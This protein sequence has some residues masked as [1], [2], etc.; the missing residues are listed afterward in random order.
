MKLSEKFLVF[1]NE[2]K[3]EHEK[4]LKENGA[5]YEYPKKMDPNIN[6]AYKR[7]GRIYR[8]FDDYQRSIWCFKYFI[9]NNAP[10]SKHDGLT[11][12]DIANASTVHESSIYLIEV[13]VYLNLSDTDPETANKLFGWAAENFV[14]PQKEFDFW[15]KQQYYD[16]IAVA[17]LW[18]GYSL[19][20][21]GEYK[22]AHELLVQVAPYLDRYKKT[23]VE[24]WRTVE[25]ALTKAVVP[26]CEYKLEPSAENLERA[27]N[28]I[29]EFIKR[30][31]ENRDKLEAYLYYFHLKEKFADIYNAD[32]PVCTSARPVKKKAKAKKL[33]K[34]PEED[35]EKPGII[36][37]TT[38][39]GGYE[40][41]L[42]TNQ[43]LEKY[44]A[45]IEEMEDFPLLASVME[46]YVMDSSIDPEFLE[47]ECRRLL[48]RKDIEK[49]MRDMTLVLLEAAMDAIGTG[50][51]LSFYLQIY[52][53]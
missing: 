22:E 14:I 16:N 40:E 11:D 6:R 42:G 48:T 15:T 35:E 3:A 10:T 53:E 30:L 4:K 20:C 52:D 24:M 13:A 9:I 2:E 33:I 27:K 28:G 37:V 19:L 45:E 7:L 1:L 36:T 43:E 21:L 34:A 51:E 31:K 46:I 47:D 12:A 25:Y 29:E 39:E 50:H 26:L 5:L 23:G 41:S 8:C 17:H 49:W 38:F 32:S 18:R 44:C